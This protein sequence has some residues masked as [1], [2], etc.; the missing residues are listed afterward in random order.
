MC[1]ALLL[2][3]PAL[4]ASAQEHELAYERERESRPWWSLY[5][6][7]S[8]RDRVL[9]AMWTLHVHQ[10]DEGWSNDKAI[11]AIYRGLYA[12]TFRTTHGPR[13]Y[14]IGL[15]RSWLSTRGSTLGA[16]LGFRAGLVY[17]YD[18][19]LGWLAEKYPVLPFAQPMLYAEVG[20]VT[21]DLTYTW[22]VM[23]LSAGLRF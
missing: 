10:L 4:G 21:T 22:V 23:S 20:P 7:A 17:G 12:G 1:A 14:S 6:T 16:M 3:V 13:A 5:S 15:E 2:A 8:D 18:G 9:W 11:T 19:R